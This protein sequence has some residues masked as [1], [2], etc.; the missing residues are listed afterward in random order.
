MNVT[1]NENNDIGHEDGQVKT[2]GVL[3]E[4][5]SRLKSLIAKFLE[6]SKEPLGLTIT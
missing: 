2:F 5:F 4:R 3:T 6:L 1:F